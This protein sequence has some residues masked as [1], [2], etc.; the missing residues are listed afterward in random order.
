M[1]K[2]T[3]LMARLS[4]EER[5]SLARLGAGTPGRRIPTEH[6]VHL[7]EYGLVEVCCGALDLTGAGKR[8]AQ[9]AA[10]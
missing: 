6:A 1:C 9:M 4:E 10:R 8:A 7:L 3:E 2:A 5:A